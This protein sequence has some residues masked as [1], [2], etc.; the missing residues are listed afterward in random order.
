MSWKNESGSSTRKKVVSPDPAPKAVVCVW[1]VHCWCADTSKDKAPFKD[2][3]KSLGQLLQIFSSYRF[4]VDLRKR[5]RRDKKKSPFFFLNNCGKTE[6][7]HQW[8]H[9]DADTANALC[10]PD[11]VWRFTQRIL[12]NPHVH[13]IGRHRRTHW[14]DEAAA[15]CWR[16]GSQVSGRVE[17]QSWM[18]RALKGRHFHA[19]PPSISSL[20][21]L[22]ITDWDA[23]NFSRALVYLDKT[24]A[25]HSW[26]S[27]A[28]S[29][30][31]DEVIARRLQF[32]LARTTENTRGRG[33]ICY[34][35]S[36][37]NTGVVFILK[38]WTSQTFSPFSLIEWTL[39]VV[40]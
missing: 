20:E 28:I 33:S 15:L 26:V 31:Q 13:S 32:L 11:T 24:C 9:E 27:Y 40:L 10:V 36:L 37:R 7:I 3:A 21:P 14:T 23:A 25:A 16:A 30:I 8:Q 18:C 39:L 2:S 17:I 5:N 12:L 19:T 29:V 35:L 22:I 4:W 6:I 34:L 38:W 1:P